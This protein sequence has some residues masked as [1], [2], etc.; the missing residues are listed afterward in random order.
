M[1]IVLLLEIQKIIGCRK[2]Q[3]ILL[4]IFCNSV[5]DTSQRMLN[6]LLPGTEVSIHRHEGTAETVVCLRGK[7]E[8][9]IYG[10]I[11][12]IMWTYA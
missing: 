11:C 2:F 7:L 9:V 4:M 1:L 5:S 12:K 8:E 10:L 3:F 6:A